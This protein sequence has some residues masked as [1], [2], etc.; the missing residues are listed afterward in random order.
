MYEQLALITSSVAYAVSNQAQCIA[1]VALLHETALHFGLE[2]QPRAASMV[3]QRSDEASTTVVTGDIARDYVRSHGGS[4]QIGM[5]L[6]AP[7]DG[8]E[9]QRAGHLVATLNNPGILLDPTFGQF[10]RAGLP[11]VVP[12]QRFT[13]TDPDVLVE[14]SWG[15]ALY[16]FDDVNQGWQASYE[17][18]RQNLSAA[19]LVLAEHINNGGQ[20]HTHPVRL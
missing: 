20:P 12:V 5:H 4:G 18:V 8:S 19:A 10:V 3:A 16:I 15:R 9:F 7:P 2:L 6:G 11:D 13:S 17:A 14:E 1:G